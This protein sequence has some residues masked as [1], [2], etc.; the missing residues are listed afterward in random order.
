MISGFFIWLPSYLY[1]MSK[2]RKIAIGGLVAVAIVTT[3]LVL[4]GYFAGIAAVHALPF[5]MLL[6]I[7]ISRKKK[8]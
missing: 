4:N 7:D 1:A 5:A 3:I 6:L 8:Q 2:M